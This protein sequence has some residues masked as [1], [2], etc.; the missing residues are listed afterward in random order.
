MKYMFFTIVCSL[1]ILA[2]FCTKNDPG[3]VNN[4]T[5]PLFLNSNGVFVLNEGNFNAGNGSLSFYSYDS[6]KLY[7]NVFFNVNGRPLG[8]VPYTMII[9][10]DKAYIVVNNSGKVEVVDK[11]TIS[12]VKTI[13]GLTSPRYVLLITNDKAYI[14]SLY[15]DKI[16]ILNLQADTVSGYIDIRRTS[17]TMLLKGDKAY[18]SCWASGNEIMIINTKTDQVIDSIEVGQEPES[19]VLDK[20]N[21]LWVLCS[22]GYTGQSN[23]ELI[24]VNTLTDEIEKRVAFPGG[25]SY[26]SSLQ[27]NKTGDTIYYLDK[28]VWSMNIASSSLPDK[29]FLPA[30]GRLYYKLAVDKAKGEILVTNVIDY[31]QKGYLLRVNS[32]GTLI[33]SSRADIIPGSLCF[34]YN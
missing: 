26:P 34:K 8:D 32:T 4:D 12:S 30:S 7:N 20:M 6:S 11:N 28:S 17:E 16:T 5:T 1:S 10:G 25:D 31:Q 2:S 9:S 22:G 18:V 3:P 13:S 21:R 15:S 24:A 29:P 23:P 33:D 19:M 27:I 14:S